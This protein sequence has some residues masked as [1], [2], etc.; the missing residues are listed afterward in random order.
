MAISGKN[1]R[2]IVVGGRAYLW[3]VV[4]TDPEY[5][6]AS[7]TAL[8]VVSADGRFGVRYFL[9]QHSDRR[10]LIVLGPEFHG[11]PNAGGPRGAGAVPGVADRTRRGARRR[12]PADRVV[13]VPGSGVGAGQPPW[14]PR[15]ME[16][17]L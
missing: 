2:K 8:M 10:Y 7:C 6:S 4:D 17:G 11:L 15:E 1:R 12:P 3:W 13:Y 16:P 5:S 14:L 9:G